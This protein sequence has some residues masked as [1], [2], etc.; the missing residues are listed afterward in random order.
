MKTERGGE[1]EDGREVEELQVVNWVAMGTKRD[2][3]TDLAKISA[4]YVV[5]IYSTGTRGFKQGIR[6]S[7]KVS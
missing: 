3:E 2:G 1:Q 7:N 6:A 4:S 5:I